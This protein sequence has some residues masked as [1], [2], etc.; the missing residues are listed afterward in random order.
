VDV[1]II[2]A[3]NRNLEEEVAS[4]GFRMDLFYRLN[5]FPISVP[6]LRERKEDIL[7]LADH[8]L[9][10]FSEDEGKNIEGFS[11][12][13]INKMENYHWPGN[14]RELENLIRRTVLLT[15]TNIVNEFYHQPETIKLT[16][17]T[18]K[19]KTITENER[20]HIMAALKSSNWKVYGPGGA[21]EL[22]NINVSTLNSRMKK[23]GIN[24]E[25]LT[26]RN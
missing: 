22:L 14:I 21:A 19:I 5:V 6:P 20:D 24:K 26:E 8:F 15:A 1:R 16:S 25:K 3:T 23:L 18:D 7:L 4:G 9:K 13:V 11:P 17:S 10:K 2:A 12:D